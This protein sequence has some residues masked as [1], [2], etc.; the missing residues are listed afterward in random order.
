[1]YPED[2]IDEEEEEAIEAAEAGEEESDGACVG[3]WVSGWHSLSL[4][5]S[6][7]RQ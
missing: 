5:L 3:E 2:D 7:Q 1:V 6:W 4:S